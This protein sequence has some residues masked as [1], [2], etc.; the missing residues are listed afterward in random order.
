MEQHGFDIGLKDL[1]L[2]IFCDIDDFCKAFEEYWHK[3][4]VTDGKKILPKSAMSLSEVMTI[5]VFFHLSGQRT[6][7]WYYNN[8][9]CGFMKDSFP[10]RLSY[11]RF[12]EVMQSS[13]VP[14][15]VYMMS[16]R[17]GK[18]SGITFIDSTSLKVCGNKRI[19]RNKVFEGIAAIG[20]ST[21][22]WFY[23]FKLHITINDEGELLSF[24]LTPGNVDDRDDKTIA[25]LTKSLF[26]K[27]FGDKGYISQKLFES[28]WDKNIHLVTGIRQNMKNR[29]MD[30]CDKILLRKRSLIETVN[31][32]LKNI[33]HI[34]H[35]RHRSPVNFMV[36]LLSGL[37]AYS[38]L[39]KRPSLGF[40]A[41]GMV[42]V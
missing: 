14:L 5:V 11:G 22:G 38:F 12:V 4:L 33:C 24:C 13:V 16:R 35:T 34:E 29:I 23:G 27:L 18:C 19:S 25:T 39:S 42:V 36:N 32:F 9:I 1:L 2:G 6:F 15:T 40:A 3:H 17:V 7:K 30:M 21:M 28:L 20:K 10:K 41:E 8:L 26:G 37:V 31:D